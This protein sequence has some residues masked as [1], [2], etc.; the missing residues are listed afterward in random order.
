MP[1]RP[2]YRYRRPAIAVALSSA[3]SPEPSPVRQFLR[4]LCHVALPIAIVGTSQIAPAEAQILGSISVESDARFRGYSLGSGDPAATLDLGYDHE[5]G[6]Y[7]NGSATVGVDQSDPALLTYQLNAGY[8]ARISP[9]VS[10]DAGAVRSWYT[11]HSSGAGDT[12]Y[13]ELYLGVTAHGISSHVYY[14]PDYLRPGIETLYAEVEST[15]NLAPEWRLTGHAGLLTHLSDPPR[16][17]RR[18]HYD[19]RAT[20]GRDL[21]KLELHASL[22]GAGP[23]SDYYSGRRHSATAVTF[24]ASLPF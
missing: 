5:S 1:A 22:S 23:G 6:L 19:W 7:L 15:I 11:R 8:A 10:I 14:S 24:G 3:P 16:Y 12:H 21:G 17:A 4:V 9:T 2:F 13:T 20:L 18:E